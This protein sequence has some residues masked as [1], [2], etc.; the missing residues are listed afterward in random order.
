[1]H[2]LYSACTFA[3]DSYTAVPEVKL[4]I[5]YRYPVRRLVMLKSHVIFA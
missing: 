2:V 5:T 3:P 1:M 4:T